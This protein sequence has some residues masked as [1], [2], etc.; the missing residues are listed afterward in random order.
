M[1][2]NCT[3]S[4][5]RIIMGGGIISPDFSNS[6]NYW[7]QYNSKGFVKPLL[8]F[9]YETN[10]NKKFVASAILHY[11]KNKALLDGAIN[12][13][14]RIDF[15]MIPK[16]EFVHISAGGLLNY[17]IFTGSKIS[18]FWKGFNVGLGLNIDNFRDFKSNFF[19]STPQRLSHEENSYQLGL[20]SNVS[21]EYKNFRLSYNLM[22]SLKR[23]GNHENL[24]Q[25]TNWKSLSASYIYTLSE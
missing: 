6:I 3:F 24:I 21:W 16:T 9:S 15:F 8:G 2:I 20:L 5:T 22:K 25:S 1:K 7:D 10:L 14:P 13:E 18:N 12:S 4:Q 19:A 17:K 11:S 23:F